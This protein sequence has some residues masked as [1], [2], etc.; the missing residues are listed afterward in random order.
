MS[1]CWP[2][3]NLFKH[4]LYWKTEIGSKG[5]WYLSFIKKSSI[6]H[7]A[8]KLPHLCLGPF[9]ASKLDRRVPRNTTF[10][11]WTLQFLLPYPL[12]QI[13]LFK[14]CST[15]AVVEPETKWCVGSC[16]RPATQADRW[17]WKCWTPQPHRLV[18]R[19]HFEFWPWFDSDFQI[20]LSF[21]DVAKRVE[22]WVN[23]NH[24]SL[25]CISPFLD[26]VLENL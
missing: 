25:F 5:A 24:R 11:H 23:W 14:L 19:R 18:S 22:G 4:N 26:S 1:F 2:F 15:I 17:K 16:C 21:E 10:L 3:G 8:E 20:S 12:F 9:A 7:V 13:L 6:S